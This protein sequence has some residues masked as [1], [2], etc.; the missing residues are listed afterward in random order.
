MIKFKVKCHWEKYYKVILAWAGTIMLSRDRKTIHIGLSSKMQGFCTQ[1][2]CWSLAIALWSQA[3]QHALLLNPVSRILFTYFQYGLFRC[4]RTRLCFAPSLDMLLSVTHLFSSDSS[5]IWLCIFAQF[6]IFYSLHSFNVVATSYHPTNFFYMD[7][8]CVFLG[9]LCLCHWKL[10]HYRW[11]LG[12]M[13]TV[14]LL[15]FFVQKQW[16]N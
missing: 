4:C 9:V 11:I 3:W 6:E 14:S 1:I 7:D 12:L 2:W 15:I 13:F 10:I 5:N 16:G 8:H